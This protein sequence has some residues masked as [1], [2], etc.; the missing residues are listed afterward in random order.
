MSERIKSF[1]KKLTHFGL[2]S[3]L[4]FSSMA[5]AGPVFL[6]ERV[7]ASGYYTDWTNIPFTQPELDNNWTPDRQ[8]PSEGYGSVDAF[9]RND[10]LNVSI[11][12]DETHTNGFNRTEGVK[13]VGGQN[14]GQIVE[15]DLYID[16]AWEDK[17]TRAGLWVVGDNGSDKR[18]GWFA[19]LDFINS[20]ECDD[21]TSHSDNA[22]DEVFS[23]FRIWDSSIGWVENLSTPFNY[24]EWVSLKI[25]LDIDN[26]QYIYYI[27]DQQVGTATGG[28]NYI[29][30]IF[31]NSYNYGLDQFSTLSDEGYSANWSNLSYGEEVADSQNP[32][33]K[34]YSPSDGDLLPGKFDVNG[35]ATDSGSGI[36]D[37]RY[38]VRE[39]VGGSLG[40]EVVSW[41]SV[42][43]NETTGEWS[44]PLSLDDGEYRIIVNTTDVAGNGR[45]KR[46]DVTVDATA[47]SVPENLS[48]T[49]TDGAVANGG[50]TNLESGTAIW[51]ASDADTERYVYHYWNDIQSSPYTG[52]SPWVNEGLMSPSAPGVF[53]QGEGTHYFSVAAVDYAGNISEFSTPFEVTYDNT[54][55][56]AT[57]TAPSDTDLLS[58]NVDISG[59]VIDDNLWRYY[60]VIK[61]SDGAVEFD[62]TVNTSEFSDES[63][64]LWDTT[65]VADGEYTIFI[66]AR[67][68]AGN[69]DGSQTTDGV[70][71]DLITV[72]VDNTDPVVSIGTLETVEPG[73]TV[74]IEGTTDDDDAEIVVTID[75]TDYSATNNG[76]GTWT[77]EITAPATDG[78]YTVTVV[79]TDEAGN[80]SDEATT[81]L[82]VVTPEGEPEETP[83]TAGDNEPLTDPNPGFVAPA[84]T[85]TDDGVVLGDQDDQTAN[86]TDEDE[87]TSEEDENGTEENGE[88]A[89]AVDEDEDGNMTLFGLAWYWWLLVLAGIVGAWYLLGAWRKRSEQ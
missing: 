13:T 76:D 25:E 44:F 43:F 14:F 8:T 83:E 34:V 6:A 81:T 21:C 70:S 66:S 77:V 31:L 56:V 16:P 48:W 46:V 36:D 73:D 65:A 52:T 80:I 68:L 37:V 60:L 79:A 26:Q 58:G 20:D 84:A 35:E 18:D 39:Y 55:P 5:V 53:N 38:R 69:K 61:D 4:A 2:A 86:T 10:V 71:T 19:I 9:G 41:T 12:E 82:V 40:S 59:S 3:V 57:I 63:L 32:Q 85:D 22:P 49:N 28:S 17:A 11:D 62:K 64:Y 27:N 74:T 45:T 54:N 75:G 47:P 29:R 23:G 50:F 67:D 87:N 24:G 89:G 7:E 33:L 78:D 15:T 88:I 1:Y 42:A 72:V 51:D 30:E